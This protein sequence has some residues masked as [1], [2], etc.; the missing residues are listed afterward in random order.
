MQAGRVENIVFSFG[1]KGICS[2]KKGTDVDNEMLT[3]GAKLR[4]N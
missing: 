2:G 4:T 1:A 3:V